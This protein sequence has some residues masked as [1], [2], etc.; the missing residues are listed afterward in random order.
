MKTPF[1]HFHR[2]AILQKCPRMSV[3]L[4]DSLPITCTPLARALLR[5][6]NR[7]GQLHISELETTC[8]QF[9]YGLSYRN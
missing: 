5:R 9:S 2:S 6:I 1:D 3:A 7:E 8:E 4:A